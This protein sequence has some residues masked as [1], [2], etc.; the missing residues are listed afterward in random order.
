[1]N[2]PKLPFPGRPNAEMQLH[3]TGHSCI[4]QQ[5]QSANDSS[6]DMAPLVLEGF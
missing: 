6:G 5:Y 1:M 2:G 3:Q 4:A